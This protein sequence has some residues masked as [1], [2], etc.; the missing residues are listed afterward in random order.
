MLHLSPIIVASLVAGDMK[1]TH[2]LGF[3]TLII[4]SII[5]DH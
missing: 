3:N 5:I 1:W 2:W 4:R